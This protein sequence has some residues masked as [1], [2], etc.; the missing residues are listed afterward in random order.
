MGALQR[1]INLSCPLYLRKSGDT[2]CSSLLLLIVVQSVRWA[3]LVL[4][5][6]ECVRVR[7]MRSAHLWMGRAPVLQDSL[8]HCV[9][10]VGDNRGLE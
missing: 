9:R 2:I 4:T 6:L 10:M 8:D 3:P 7:T 1:R 5:V